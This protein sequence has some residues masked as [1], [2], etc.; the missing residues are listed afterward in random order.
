MEIV[1]Y[2]YLTD[3]RWVK[4][5]SNMVK[6][7]PI[8]GWH[9]YYKYQFAKYVEQLLLRKKHIIVCIFFIWVIFNALVIH[10]KQPV[11]CYYCYRLARRFSGVCLVKFSCFLDCL[12]FD[13]IVVYT[14]QR[15]WF[16]IRHCQTSHLTHWVIVLRLSAYIPYRFQMRLLMKT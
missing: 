2:N 1:S 6:R 15:W 10:V 12:V 7:C 11:P 4:K 8:N 14:N 9:Q 5:W 3:D 13:Y 16:N